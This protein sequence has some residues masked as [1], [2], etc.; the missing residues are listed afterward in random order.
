MAQPDQQ[1][2]VNMLEKWNKVR[3]PSNR[4]GILSRLVGEW[5]VLLRFRGGGQ[6]WES[7]C[8]SQAELMHGGRFLLEQIHG[9]IYAPDAGG[10]MRPEAY[11]ATRM[12]GFDNYKNAYTGMFVDN[13]N[14]YLL[15]FQGHDFSESAPE[16][17]GLFGR[18]DEP[19][20]DTH[21]VMMKYELR[22]LD[23]AR[24]MW[25]VYVTAVSDDTSLF[26]F[27]YEKRS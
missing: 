9:E 11:S 6:A 8:I 15:T 22:F 17:L 12:L 3:V 5:D 13:Q 23:S 1:E 7:S 4:H 21:D 16:R 24:H 10:E 27:E 26:D 2:F 19:M 25:S 18:Q 14:T 20:L